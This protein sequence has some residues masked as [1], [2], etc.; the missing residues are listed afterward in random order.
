MKNHFVIKVD[1]GFEKNLPGNI[2][3][4]KDL[5]L[6]KSVAVEMFY[7]AFDDFFRYHNLKCWITKEYQPDDKNWNNEEIAA[8]LNLQYRIIL[9]EDYTLPSD[10]LSRLRSLP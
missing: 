2:P 1:K 3:Y 5:I 9:Q 8:E 4:W 6:D 10:F 7:P